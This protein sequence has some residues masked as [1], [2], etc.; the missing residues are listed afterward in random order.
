[1]LSAIAKDYPPTSVL[2]MKQSPKKNSSQI[3]CW[4]FGRTNTWK[5]KNTFEAKTQEAIAGFGEEAIS[6]PKP[7]LALREL[8]ERVGTDLPLIQQF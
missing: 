8:L 3:D 2:A 5:I 4:W 7:W 6:K 1:M